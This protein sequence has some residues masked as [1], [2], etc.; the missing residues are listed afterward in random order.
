MAKMKLSHDG[1]IWKGILAQW[2]KEKDKLQRSESH[3]IIADTPENRDSAREYWNKRNEVKVLINDRRLGNPLR[4]GDTLTELALR[5]AKAML[6]SARYRIVTTSECSNGC[7]SCDA[8]DLLADRAEL[9][10]REL[11]RGTARGTKLDREVNS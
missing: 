1:E 6:E 2:K 8:R 3:K 11:A 10:D 5:A 9:I 4:Y 7:A